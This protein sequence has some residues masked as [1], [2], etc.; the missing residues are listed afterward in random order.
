MRS[1]SCIDTGLL[2]YRTAVTDA[3]ARFGERW[4]T[5]VGRVLPDAPRAATTASYD[6]PDLRCAPA[7]RSPVADPVFGP[8][9]GSKK[10]DNICQ[11]ESRQRQLN[12]TSSDAYLALASWAYGAAAYPAE[13]HPAQRV[14]TEMQGC[15]RRGI[16]KSQQEA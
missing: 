7:G 3:N 12:I 15:N 2:P 14:T 6:T 1:A 4:T 8:E 10:S 16:S 9:V 13:P 5:G 11:V